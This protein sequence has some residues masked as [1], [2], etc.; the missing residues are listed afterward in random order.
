MAVFQLF[1]IPG[2][3]TGVRRLP[4]PTGEPREVYEVSRTASPDPRAVGR[5]ARVELEL[6]GSGWQL[7][8]GAIARITDGDLTV[9]AIT[10]FEPPINA[11]HRGLSGV[12][13]HLARDLGDHALRVLEGVSKTTVGKSVLVITTTVSGYKR[14][15]LDL[16][17]N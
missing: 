3:E 6:S 11:G 1:P 15:Y 14:Q 7:I 4:D 10:Q 2:L 8:G 13:E 12:G 17:S 5:A 9:T 16:A